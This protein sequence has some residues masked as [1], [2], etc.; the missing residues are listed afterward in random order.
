MFP[1]SQR[2]ILQ[3]ALVERGITIGIF[4]DLFHVSGHLDQFDVLYF[5]VQN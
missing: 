3:G 2:D 1:A 5:L 4:I